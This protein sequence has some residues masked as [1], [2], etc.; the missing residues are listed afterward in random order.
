[1]T[2]PR[3][4][5]LKADG[6]NCDEESVV[7]CELA[8]A[9]AQIVHL[10]TLVERPSLLF[11]FQLLT[12]AG[13]FSYG[14]DIA[15][16]RILAL[17]LTT[18]LGD[19]IQRFIECGGIIIG[20]CNGFQILTEMGLL[21]FG[22]LGP[23]DARLARNASGEFICRWVDLVTDQPCLF[24]KGLE[25]EAISWQIRHGEGRWIAKDDVVRRV[26]DEGLVALRYAENPNGSTNDIAGLCYKT[27]FGCMPHPE[28]NVIV[29][30]HP[31]W[32]RGNVRPLGLTIFKN[33][34]EHA[35][36]R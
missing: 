11:E 21:P 3:A 25:G 20:I 9:K 27:I 4:L 30:N 8:G 5:I 28:L 34:A 18:R 22:K 31:N 17:I 36:Q 16:G 33:A 26:E 29:E 35:A 10:N 1:M 32:R 15:A 23:P 7:A 13:G 12:L 2:K 14:D 19:V 6:V 24:T